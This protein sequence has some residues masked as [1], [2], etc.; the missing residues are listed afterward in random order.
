MPRGVYARHYRNDPPDSWPVGKVELIRRTCPRCHQDL[1][2][3]AK[4]LPK[5]RADIYCANC[6]HGWIGRL[7]RVEVE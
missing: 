4:R 7:K 3:Q 5:H 1:Y 2:H 6:G